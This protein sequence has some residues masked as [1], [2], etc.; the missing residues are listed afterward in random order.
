MDGAILSGQTTKWTCN[1][2]ALKVT[3]PLTLEERRASGTPFRNPTDRPDLR[4]RVVNLDAIAQTS[5][6]DG[7]AQQSISGPGGCAVTVGSRRRGT[8]EALQPIGLRLV[9]D[10]T[11]RWT[12]GTSGRVS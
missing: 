8:H 5:L 6:S 7:A 10:F 11:R 12:A 3:L 9:D 2:P 4:V 1:E